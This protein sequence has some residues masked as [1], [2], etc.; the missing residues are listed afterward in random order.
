MTT[1]ALK[2][3]SIISSSVSAFPLQKTNPFAI[4]AAVSTLL[5]IAYFI[6][7]HAGPLAQL[8]RLSIL[9]VVVLPLISF[10]AAAI[11][12][13]QLQITGERG[14]IVSYLSLALTSLYLI[15]GMAIPV[16]LLG[17]YLL[18]TYVL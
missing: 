2:Q 5:F 1:V 3:N 9:Y 10:A 16:V 8:F 4:I 15:V 11:A 12:L 6:V 13:R 18:Y 14:V 7:P 17:L